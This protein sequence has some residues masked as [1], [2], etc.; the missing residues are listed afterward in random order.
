MEPTRN[1]ELIIA[2]D[3]GVTVVSIMEMGRNIWIP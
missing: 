3:T 1:R 2:T